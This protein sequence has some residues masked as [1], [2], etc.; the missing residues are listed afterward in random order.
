[1][2]VRFLPVESRGEPRV[3][4]D[5][6]SGQYQANLELVEV[7]G[8]ALVVVR[9]CGYAGEEVLAIAERR[10]EDEIYVKRIFAFAACSPAQLAAINSRRFPVAGHDVRTPLGDRA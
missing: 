5:A 8:F 3:E 2:S 4:V 10:D 7:D 9:P 6:A 1:M